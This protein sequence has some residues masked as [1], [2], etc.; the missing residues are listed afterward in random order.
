MSIPKASKREVRSIRKQME[1]KRETDK[2]IHEIE[3]GGGVRRA[4]DRPKPAVLPEVWSSGHHI[5]QKLLLIASH[6]HLFLQAFGQV[7]RH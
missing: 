6:W 1:R 4:L 5:S 2:H 7:P 3:V